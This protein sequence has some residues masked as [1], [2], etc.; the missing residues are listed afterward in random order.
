MEHDDLDVELGDPGRDPSNGDV[1][2]DAPMAAVA[3]E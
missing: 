2:V 1:D 3:A